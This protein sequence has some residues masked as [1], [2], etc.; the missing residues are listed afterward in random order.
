[1]ENL[2]TSTISS[3]SL[4]VFLLQNMSKMLIF[5]VK[6]FL[7]HWMLQLWESFWDLQAFSF[8]MGSRGRWVCWH[9]L[10]TGMCTQAKSETCHVLT[11]SYAGPLRTPLKTHE[12]CVWSRTVKEKKVMFWEVQREFPHTCRKLF[13]MDLVFQMFWHDTDIKQAGLLWFQKWWREFM[14][15]RPMRTFKASFIELNVFAF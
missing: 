13:F 1:M 10:Y 15:L 11:D 9:C 3:F 2:N 14:L 7:M 12:I 4:T 5:S 6:I 8:E